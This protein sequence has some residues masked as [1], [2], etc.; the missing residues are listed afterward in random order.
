MTNLKLKK[1]SALLS[2]SVLAL[3]A[4]SAETT[5]SGSVYGYTEKDITTDT[6]ST[7]ASDSGTVY[8]DIY[9]NSSSDNSSL[10]IEQIFSLDDSDSYA[11]AYGSLY[12]NKM[13]VT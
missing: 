11:S 12:S 13:Y 10:V 4:L 9:L 3:C 7:V 2:V 1:V 6:G 8:G 5:F